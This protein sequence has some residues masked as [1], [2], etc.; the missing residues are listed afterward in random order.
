MVVF[1]ATWS[2]NAMAAIPTPLTLRQNLIEAQAGRVLFR[3]GAVGTAN[4]IC[5]V[6][7]DLK[8]NP[9]LGQ[10]S[11]IASLFLTYQDSGGHGGQA[12]VSAA[13]RFIRMVDGK[14]DGLSAG[15]VQTVPKSD[16][17]SNSPGA[18]LSGGSGGW[19]THRSCSPPVSMNSTHNFDPT[20]NYYYVQ[21]TLTRNQPIFS[22][23]A[24]GVILD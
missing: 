21:I 18:P 8:W 1:H 10:G 9:P 17:S 15:Q 19:A 11:P 3:D 5:P 6:P 2:I 4:L 12:G 13:L 23:A 14:P 7:A 22:C 20:I 16:V 24:M